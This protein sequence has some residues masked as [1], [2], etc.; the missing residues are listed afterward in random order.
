MKK[1]SDRREIKEF[2]NKDSEKVTIKARARKNIK[3]TKEPQPG[4]EYI[5][6]ML[7]WYSFETKSRAMVRELM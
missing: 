5:G 2:E 6:H 7:D 4:Q 3:D 1:E